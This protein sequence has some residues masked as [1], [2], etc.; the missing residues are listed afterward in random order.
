MLLL[1]HALV[2]AA[3]AV[4]VCPGCFLTRTTHGARCGRRY[5]VFLGIEAEHA[6]QGEHEEPFSAHMLATLRAVAKGNL[7][8]YPD[9]RVKEIDS[10]V[11]KVSCALSFDRLGHIPPF[12]QR[13]YAVL[14]S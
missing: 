3:S 11:L 7:S 6:V 13:A 10:E 12:C 2:L 1:G 9:V 14:F 8:A 5:L 4:H